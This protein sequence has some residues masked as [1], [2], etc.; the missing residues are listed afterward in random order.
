MAAPAEFTVNY[1][2]GHRSSTIAKRDSL[3]GAGELVVA[4]D[5]WYRSSLP[6]SRWGSP[7]ADG[8]YMLT[9]HYLEEKLLLAP[10]FN[11]SDTLRGRDLAW[12]ITAARFSAFFHKASLTGT[13]TT[14]TTKTEATFCAEIIAAAALM[15]PADLGLTSSG[16]IAYADAASSTFFDAVTPRRIMGRGSSLQNVGLFKSMMACGYVASGRDDANG[17]FQM[18]VELLL[19]KAGKDLAGKSANI[20]A[21]DVVKFINDTAPDPTALWHYA[22]PDAQEAEIQRRASPTVSARFVPLLSAA[23]TAGNG[24]YEEMRTAFPDVTDGPDAVQLMSVL[25]TRAGLPSDLTH[26]VC[27]S[28]CDRV[29]DLLPTLNTSELRTASGA[30]RGRSLGALLP[31]AGKGEA[32]EAKDHSKDTAKILDASTTFQ[33]LRGKLEAEDVDHPVYWHVVKIMAAHP[34]IAGLLY[35]ARGLQISKLF[36]QFNPARATQTMDEAFN[37]HMAFDAVGMELVPKAVKPGAAAMLINAKFAPDAAG[38]VDVWADIVSPLLVARNGKEALDK[39]D[40]AE[41][42]FWTDV[43][44]LRIA[45]DPLKKAFAFIGY[46]GREKGSFVSFYTGIDERAVMVDDL[47]VWC[48]KR[49]GLV[50]SLRSIADHGLEEAANSLAEALRATLD[51]AVRPKLFVDPDG[52]AMKAMREF[53]SDIKKVMDE[54]RLER[55][56]QED[57]NQDDDG[58]GGGGKRPKIASRALGRLN[59]SKGGTSTAL[60][61]RVPRDG[62]QSDHGYSKA[63]IEEWEAKMRA[64]VGINLTKHTVHMC[65]SP[66]GLVFGNAYFVTLT[67]AKAHIWSTL[68][69]GTCLGSLCHMFGEHEHRRVNWCDQECTSTSHPRPAGLTDDDFVVINLAMPANEQHAEIARAVIADRANWVALGGTENSLAASFALHDVASSLHNTRSSF[70]LMDCNGAY[71]AWSP[72]AGGKAEKGGGGKG[73]KGG[74]GGR[75]NGGGGKGARGSHTKGAGRLGKGSGGKGR[76]IAKKSVDFHRQR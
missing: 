57:G 46:V 64:N 22:E 40:N 12:V 66:T 41:R 52:H 48:D 9:Q 44:R 29:H 74:K 62:R 69:P 65:D 42:S 53:D 43:A 56:Y 39:Y 67:A 37:K 34:H 36:M 76:G 51:N 26:T 4:A 14:S 5:S 18:L 60:V 21:S 27:V 7:L 50:V 63:D 72:I 10:G 33:D 28:L 71:T 61:T 55:R 35:L 75:S 47:P 3:V 8:T 68:P 54:V 24:M 20:Q 25:A 17:D 30:S 6:A 32:S 19:D 38:N 70:D 73:G 31:S 11:L 58:G 2:P 45:A 59:L 1:R 23:W 13:I 16:V 49:R 15:A